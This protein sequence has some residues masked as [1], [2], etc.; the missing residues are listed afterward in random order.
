MYIYVQI[1]NKRNAKV[2]TTCN[3][4][5]RGVSLYEKGFKLALIY[6]APRLDELTS[7]NRFLRAPIFL[8]HPINLILGVFGRA[9]RSFRPKKPT[10]LQNLSAKHNQL[11]QLHRDF[12]QK[13]TVV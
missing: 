10:P 7:I 11:Q 3:L 6:P 1:R 9:P 13:K 8:P 4:K 12:A 5:L 2:K